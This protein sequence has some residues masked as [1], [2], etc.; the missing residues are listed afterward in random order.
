MQSIL[1]VTLKKQSVQ[2]RQ[3]M[4]VGERC[5]KEAS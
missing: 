3:T 4:A 2:H 1:S 5:L